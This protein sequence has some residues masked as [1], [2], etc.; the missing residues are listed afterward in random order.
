MAE[1]TDV[2]DLIDRSL[3][4][5]GRAI[6]GVAP[7]QQDLATPCASWN[8]RALVNH[9]VRDTQQF[10]LMARGEKWAP[11]SIDL[12]PEDWSRTFHDDASSLLSAWREQGELDDAQRGRASQQIAEFAVHTWDIARATSQRMTLDDDVAEEG[13][14][15]A[16][17][18]LK[19]EYRGSEESGKVFGPEVAVAADAP[20]PDRLAAWFGRDPSWRP[21]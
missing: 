11:G 16:Q 17:A 9:V 3:D 21:D 5:A 6:D 15:W 8:V 13:L 20:L 4:Q 18:N 19:P 1:D 2:I 14:S 10:A 12:P 7:D